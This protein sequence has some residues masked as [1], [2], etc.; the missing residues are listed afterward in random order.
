M[1][2][3]VRCYFIVTK[4]PWQCASSLS[5]V[6][7]TPSLPTSQI[8]L[9]VIFWN[10]QNWNQY[11]KD[12]TDDKNRFLKHITRYFIRNFPG[13]LCEVEAAYVVYEQWRRVLVGDKDQWSVIWIKINKVSSVFL[14]DF[15]DLEQNLLSWYQISHIICFFLMKM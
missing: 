15:V 8:R 10:F 6:P 7:V 13:L 11:W 3:N 4:Q 14:I 9:P 5:L 12:A 1:A 2:V